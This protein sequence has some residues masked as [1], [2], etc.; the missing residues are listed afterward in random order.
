MTSNAAALWPR[1]ARHVLRVIEFH[2]EAFFEA[3]GKSL[4]RGIVTVHARV[5]DRA[6]GH[7]R[8]GELRQMTSGTV[9]VTR[10]DGLS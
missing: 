4:S 3:I 5:A 8:R 2:V 9:L 7:V 10:E 6:H 1:R